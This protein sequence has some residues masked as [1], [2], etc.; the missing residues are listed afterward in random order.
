MTTL[1][2]GS[3]ET[4][5]PYELD[6]THLLKIQDVDQISDGA[7]F[8]VETAIAEINEVVP[9]DWKPTFNHGPALTT[10]CSSHINPSLVDKVHSEVQEPYK[11][12]RKSTFDGTPIKGDVGNIMRALRNLARSDQI[13][14]VCDKKKSAKF[15]RIGKRMWQ[16][17][18]L[19]FKGIKRN[20]DLPT[21][22]TINLFIKQCAQL[23]V[24]IVLTPGDSGK[25]Y[26][27]GVKDFVVRG[28]IDDSYIDARTYMPTNAVMRLIHFSEQDKPN[29][30]ISL[31][32]KHECDQD[33]PAT[34][35]TE[36]LQELVHGIMQC[37]SVIC[38]QC[39]LKSA[40]RDAHMIREQLS[41]SSLL[42]QYLQTLGMEPLHAIVSKLASEPHLLGNE[43][44]L[45]DLS[46]ALKTKE[47]GQFKLLDMVVEAICH[48]LVGDA[49]AFEKV[50]EP[51]QTLYNHLEKTQH[52]KEI[53]A[54]I[55]FRNKFVPRALQYSQIIADGLIA[56]GDTEF[57]DFS[58]F[59]MFKVYDKYYTKIPTVQ[60]AAMVTTRETHQTTRNLATN[61]LLIEKDLS[62]F[63]EQLLTTDLDQGP[64]TDD[65]ITKCNRKTVYHA[66]CVTDHD[67]N[68]AESH[69][70]FPTIGYMGVNTDEIIKMPRD[71]AQLCVAKDGYCYM[72]IFM[73]MFMHV[74]SLAITQ[75]AERILKLGDE[76]GEWPTLQDVAS[77]CAKLCIFFP[78]VQEAGLP[79]ILIDHVNKTIHVVDMFGSN[80]TG[81]HILKANTVKQL[82]SFSQPSVSSPL[83]NY[84]VG[85]RDE[86]TGL[87]ELLKS[88]TSARRFEKQLEVDPYLIIY[89]ALSPTVIKALHTSGSLQVAIRHFMV[90][91]TT[92]RDISTM[93]RTMAKKQSVSKSYIQQIYYTRG[94]LHHLVNNMPQPTK[95]EHRN[96][97][98]DAQNYL[99]QLYQCVMANT[100][101]VE[102][103]FTNSF[104]WRLEQEKMLEEFQQ[105]YLAELPYCARL[106]YLWQQYRQSRVDSTRNDISIATRLHT[107]L[108]SYT[109]ACSD[110]TCNTIVRV[111]EK[112][113]ALIGR[114]RQKIY[115]VVQRGITSGILAMLPDL[116]THVGFGAMLAMIFVLLGV[117]NRILYGYRQYKLRKW[118]EKEERLNDL[119][120][121]YWFRF[122]EPGAAYNTEDMNA[123]VQF[124]ETR[125]KEVAKHCR[126]LFHKDI[127][128]QAKT[129]HQVNYEKIIA[130]MTLFMMY[131]DNV[132]SDVLY[133]TL[134]KLK[135]IF[136]TLGQETIMLQSEEKIVLDNLVKDQAEE[137]GFVHFE[138]VNNKRTGSSMH[139]VKFQ[140]FWEQQLRT[141]RTI[142]HQRGVGNFFEFTRS[143]AD[144]VVNQIGLSTDRMFTIRGPVGSGKSTALPYMLHQKG[145]V[146]ILEPTRPLATNV[147]KQLYTEQWNHTYAS[148]RMRGNV[149][150]GTPQLNVMTTGYALRHYLNNI[151]ELSQID[152]IL[153]DE[154]HVADANADAFVSMLSQQRHK[155]KILFVSATPVGKEAEFKPPY[156][157]EIHS[158]ENLSFGAFADNQKTGCDSDATKYGCNILVYVASYNDVD[159]LAHALNSKGFKTTLIDGRTMKNGQTE[160]PTEGTPRKPHFIIATNIIE[161]GVTLD[162]D[163]VIDFGQKVVPQL[164]L[165]Q[166]L[167]RC[168]RESVT[169]GERIQRSGRVGRT[170]PGTVIKIGNTA[171]A[172][173]HVPEL[174]AT[175]AAFLCFA[176]DLPL[177]TVNVASS[178]L[179]NCTRRQ[180][181]TMMNIELPIY[182]TK[183]LVHYDGSVHP[184][185]MKILTPYVHNASSIQ[186]SENALPWQTSSTW[187]DVHHYGNSQQLMDLEPSTRIPFLANEV[188]T[189][190][191]RDIWTA[192]NKHKPKPYDIQ[193]RSIP[194]QKI[195]ITLESDPTAIARSIRIIDELLA[196]EMAKKLELEQAALNGTF[197][198][199]TMQSLVNRIRANYTTT[200]CAANID[201]LEQIKNELAT[202]KTF[203]EDELNGALSDTMYGLGVIT[204]QSKEEVVQHLGLRGTY[205]G[206]KIT[207]DILL[208]FG[209]LVGSLWMLFAT[210]KWYADDGFILES[211]ETKSIEQ[212]IT[213]SHSKD[214]MAL[215]ARNL[216]KRARQKQSYQR[217]RDRKTYGED[218]VDFDKETASYGKKKGKPRTHQGMKQ[219]FVNMYGVSPDEYSLVRYLDPITGF[220]IDEQ[221]NTSNIELVREEFQG[222][223]S[224]L[225]EEFQL[226]PGHGVIPTQLEAYVYNPDTQAALK[227][228]LTLHDSDYRCNNGRVAG[229]SN[230]DGDLR[231]S[232]RATP[233]SIASLPPQKPLDSLNLEGQSTCRGIMDLTP[234]ATHV[235]HATARFYKSNILTENSLRGIAYGNLTIL[236]SHLFN[237]DRR[238]LTFK[239]T[240][241]IFVIPE[242]TEIHVRQ[243]DKL[244]ILILRNP[245]DMP[246]FSKKLNFR[247]PK[248]GECVFLLDNTHNSIDARPLMSSQSTVY[249]S[250]Q[251]YWVHTVSTKEGQCG[252]PIVAVSDLAIVGIHTGSSTTRNINYFT[253]LP[254]DFKTTLEDEL[255]EWKTNWH[256]KP[257]LVDWQGHKIAEEQPSEITADRI[258]ATLNL[259]SKE[260]G[261]TWFTKVLS[262]NLQLVGE[263]RNTLITKHVIRGHNHM[264]KLF[265]ELHDDAK[266]FFE[267]L[268]DH[269][270]PSRLNKDAFIKD[271]MKYS[272]P[273]IVGVLDQ[274]LLTQATNKVVEVLENA[275]IEKCVYVTDSTSIFQSLNLD[276]ATGVQY[277]GKKKTFFHGWNEDD[278]TIYHNKCLKQLFEGKMGIW[279][280]SLKAELRPNAKVLENKTRVYTAAP[281][282]VLVA[283]KTCVDD[284][285][286]QFYD[287]HLAG[288][289]TVGITKFRGGWHQFLTKFPDTWVYC[290]ADGS[291]FDSSLAPVLI[292][293]VCDIRIQFQESWPIGVEMLR[294]LYTQIVYTPI[295][296]P[297]GSVIKKF[298]GNNSG[299][300]STVVDNTLMVIISMEYA[301]IKL[302][303]NDNEII[304]FCN[305]DDLAIAIE[306]TRADELGKFSDIFSTLGLCYDFSNIVS[307]RTQIS[308]MSH[309]GIQHD[310]IYIPKLEPERIVAILQWNR[311]SEFEHELDALN[312][313]LIESYGYPQ[314]EHYIRVYYN[315]LLEQHPYNTLATIGRAPY[316]SKLALRNLYDGKG[317]TSDETQLY[318]EAMKHIPT[319]DTLHLQAGETAV[320]PTLTGLTTAPDVETDSAK[321][322]R[323]AA[324]KAIKD[325][326]KTD[327]DAWD[328]AHPSDKVERPSTSAVTSE[329]TAAGTE[330]VVPQNDLGD[331]KHGG[332]VYKPPKLELEKRRIRIPKVGGKPAINAK[333]LNSLTATSYDL[334]SKKS[335]QRQFEN[336]YNGAKK[337]YGLDDDAFQLLVTAFVVWC[338]HNGTSDKTTGN[339]KAKFGDEEEDYPVGPF[340]HHAN[341]T[342]RQT[343]MHYSDV[344]EQYIV[345]QNRKHKFMPRWGMQRNILDYNYAQYAFDFYEV[346]DRTPPIARNLIMN[347]KA[348]AVRNGGN[349]I[350]GL[351][352]N[353]TLKP[354][355]LDHHTVAD[356]EVGRITN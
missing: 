300:P 119:I 257:D 147:W 298:K 210:V 224:E 5:V 219:R 92:L 249:K 69:I 46:L 128:L 275:G 312:A 90:K 267:P 11:S 177:M 346:T 277:G 231:Q 157:V 303:I 190:F 239:T 52:L 79:R 189:R 47:D 301:K 81:Y 296:T 305:G 284:F 142:Q 31:P 176:Y 99:N 161:N 251:N 140:D 318:K 50:H 12:F 54:P 17:H 320:K 268:L 339:F 19:H 229:F 8:V 26:R 304:Y 247:G 171:P 264:F 347:T 350:L 123:F 48:A 206:R 356:R 70:I 282:E 316:I 234:L 248:Q 36:F 40:T 222:V 286:N 88:T 225:N 322:T 16:A 255:S 1:L 93:L 105:H 76:L 115:Q 328:A 155:A 309:R 77:Q 10:Q 111:K 170:R 15:N 274:K 130:L 349:K 230:H 334:S 22:E 104:E 287:H 330:S 135:T 84:V 233:I 182:V 344:A 73:N 23:E 74:N 75:L 354:Q 200:D 228:D 148:L 326:F 242:G 291:R 133:S 188:P 260:V 125:D 323:L 129:K 106:R 342:L 35:N 53:P 108:R 85:G 39:V 289:W 220:T 9:G 202:C 256:F 184:S 41:K 302:G 30:K 100:Q 86:L 243:V 194:R 68:A 95:A 13:V 38:R 201:K 281:V 341:P 193:L 215:E 150:I 80:T 158:V 144:T 235:V 152:Y 91:D 18:V 143:T 292:N 217:A 310:D 192:I 103:G 59:H 355:E 197:C 174:V 78:S 25:I 82:V 60:Q 269:Y 186:T 238:A 166:R 212:I 65:C 245:K 44:K 160:I 7:P 126:K 42:T 56:H 185:I 136:S 332:G 290:H 58:A 156:P 258:F 87:K 254:D 236:P 29:L 175:E 62:K 317:V 167:I 221:T 138:L 352:G 195:M 83:K 198:Q 183:Y 351:D 32:I 209:V 252:T 107:T 57:W 55:N 165:D 313:A 295:A 159:T 343:M 226:R 340:V 21:G 315:W 241:G 272:Q 51:L 4:F 276:A 207:H 285:N 214:K 117:F 199:G 98:T 154:C 333:A 127:T 266:E 96:T 146:L 149:I 263:L 97:C 168:V 2:F 172:P 205:D 265:L 120:S 131:F 278:F 208:G 141:G 283:A 280:G 114:T 213:E 109:Q 101:L 338:I 253:A 293:A 169:F 71:V 187:F 324:N 329:E 259:Q 66:S 345:D 49:R 45:T 227:I 306:P 34:L 204:L 153:F 327:S 246:P 164:D 250:T 113:T 288:P 112:C 299:Q 89:S 20:R 244:D 67:G 132:K 191:Y 294:N 14:E 308:F 271:I 325:R 203:T 335:T 180:A 61:L 3:I 179:D 261:Y 162:I 307:D 279:N 121:L 297:D 145:R 151:S 118:E 321:T 232:G 173:L 337:D 122:F 262:G 94:E 270:S 223:R 178:F 273:T 102:A 116:K 33:F 218:V 124:V 348:A 336:W 237:N 137:K 63:R 196:A 37:T 24:P 139:D 27:D 314:L 181:R 110:T 43:D 6:T 319:F 163:V 331:G 64:I 211:H 240:R 134:N 216:S 353:V 28:C 72:N 311:T